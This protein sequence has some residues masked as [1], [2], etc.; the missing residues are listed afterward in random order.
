[1]EALKKQKDEEV[2]VQKEA[3]LK[4]QTESEETHIQGGRRRKEK[5]LRCFTS[6]HFFF[7]FGGGSIT[8]KDV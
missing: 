7:F 3:L 2:E 1:M 6:H 8:V 5:A 4:M